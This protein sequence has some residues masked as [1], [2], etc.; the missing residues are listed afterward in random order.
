MGGGHPVA[1]WNG[2]LFVEKE[3]LPIEVEILA[4]CEGHLLLRSVNSESV[5]NMGVKPSVGVQ[6]RQSAAC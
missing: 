2:F 4:K 3:G 5:Q 1:K 6:F